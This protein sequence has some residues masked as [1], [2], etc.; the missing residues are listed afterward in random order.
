MP[1]RIQYFLSNSKIRYPVS[2]WDLIVAEKDLIFNTRFPGC[3]R[4][5]LL[6]HTASVAG[7]TRIILIIIM[8]III[9]VVGRVLIVAV[10]I[11]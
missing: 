4:N 6:L 10:A 7:R 8:V 1:R 3:G 2:L 5:L 11:I 9:I